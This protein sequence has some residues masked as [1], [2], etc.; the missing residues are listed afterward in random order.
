MAYDSWGLLDASKS[1]VSETDASNSH[2]SR[3]ISTAYYAIFQHVCCASA[4]LLV[5]GGE[6]YLTSAK[7][8]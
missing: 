7:N 1:L 4:D 8:I 2:V 6:N 3:A 5:G